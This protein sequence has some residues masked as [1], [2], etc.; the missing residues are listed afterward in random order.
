MGE[1]G[2]DDQEDMAPEAGPP[3]EPSISSDTPESAVLKVARDPGDPTM[4]E[5][6]DHNASHT[7]FRSWCPIF[8]KAKGREE[9]HRNGRRKEELSAHKFH[10]ITKLLAKRTTE[11]TR[12][13]P[14]CTKTITPKRF[15]DMFASER[16]H[17]TRE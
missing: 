10:S 12:Q 6:E 11:M 16:E 3:G 8:A 14:L 13:Q 15:L 4:K 1:E 9:A 7:P 2:V 5:R 17:Q